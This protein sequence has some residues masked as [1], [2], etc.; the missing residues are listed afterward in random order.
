MSK[1]EGRKEGKKQFKLQEGA[2]EMTILEAAGNIYCTAL[3]ASTLLPHVSQ[4]CTS[5]VEI[6]SDSEEMQ[7]NTS[8]FKVKGSYTS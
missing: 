8:V 7:L 5:N 4:F 2:G 6:N 1:R 3:T